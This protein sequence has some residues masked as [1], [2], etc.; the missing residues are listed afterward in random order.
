MSDSHHVVCA[1]CAGVNRVPA[2]RDPAAARCGKCGQ[3]LFGGRP[4]DLD[5]AGFARF[6]ERN[7]RPVV[8]DFWAAWCGPCRT[9]APVFEQAAADLEPSVRFARVDTERARAV[10]VKYGIRS[11]PTLILFRRGREVSRQSGAMPLQALKQWIT[12]AAG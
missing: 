7:D 6:V 5:D 10:S 9:M 12:R 11:I 8:V 4:A 3:P 2:D 1:A